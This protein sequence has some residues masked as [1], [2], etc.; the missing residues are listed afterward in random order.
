MK[1]IHLLTVSLLLAFAAVLGGIAAFRTAHLG[2]SARATPVSAAAIARRNRQLD[3]VE[4]S[5]RQAL[6][7][8]PPTPSA[9][10]SRHQRIV[11]VRP[12]PV[13]HIVHRRGGEHEAARES[14]DD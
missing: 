7:Q 5:L 4:L 2:A 11:F 1:R 8:K 9:A 3:R 14:S 13:V 10:P 12:A 6:G